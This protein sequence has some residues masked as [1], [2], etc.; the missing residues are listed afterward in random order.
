MK[1]EPNVVENIDSRFI[2]SQSFGVEV[3]SRRSMNSAGGDFGGNGDWA[4]AA[5]GT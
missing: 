5:S 3:L 1:V 4:G 2:R